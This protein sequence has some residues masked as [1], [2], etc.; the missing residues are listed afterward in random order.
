VSSLPANCRARPLIGG[1]AV[2]LPNCSVQCVRRLL[3]SWFVWCCFRWCM[4]CVC[5]GYCSVLCP[6]PHR[7]L[8]QGKLVNACMPVIKCIALYV[9]TSTCQALNRGS[10]RVQDCHCACCAAQAAY[11][12]WQAHGHGPTKCYS[13]IM[14]TR[15]SSKLRTQYTTGI[16]RTC[17]IQSRALKAA[18]PPDGNGNRVIDT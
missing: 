16:Q 1:A 14:R 5:A 11:Y 17:M 6:G 2:Q 3:V 15:A 9:H 13:T 12:G 8:L 4:E 18:V 10:V 7:R